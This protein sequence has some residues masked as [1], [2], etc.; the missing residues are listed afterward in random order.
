MVSGK[1]GGGGWFR[2]RG[3]GH[4]WFLVRREGGWFLVCGEVRVTVK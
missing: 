4:G 1:E 2:V 3:E